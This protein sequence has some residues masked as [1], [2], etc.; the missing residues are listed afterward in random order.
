MAKTN[1]SVVVL[2]G[3]PSYKEYPLATFDVYGD[4]AITPG[5][6]VEVNTG[7]AAPHGSSAGFAL[8][9]FA[10]EGLN[11]DTD[12]KTMGDIDVDYAVEGEPVKVGFFHAGDE[13]YALLAA[14][15]DVALGA[16]LE[17]N[18]DGYLKA[19]TTNAIVRTLAA[20][21]N[22]PGTGPARIKVEVL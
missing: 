1:P 4:G 6:L 17:S 21:D 11:I 7:Y 10:V 3:E 15:Q 13:V 12:S 2:K 5:M 19:G 22:N 20:L 14:G 16:R 18:G 8:P 9:T